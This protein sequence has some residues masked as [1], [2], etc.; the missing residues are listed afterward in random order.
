M[1]HFTRCLE[2][3]C[4]TYIIALKTTYP[5]L[6]LQFVIPLVGTSKRP[7]SVHGLDLSPSSR[8]A[9]SGR[10]SVPLAD[11]RSVCLARVHFLPVAVTLWVVRVVPL[12]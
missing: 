1:I 5:G 9:V 11:V 7:K 3:E 4:F 8:I 2:C 12:G 10:T 6:A